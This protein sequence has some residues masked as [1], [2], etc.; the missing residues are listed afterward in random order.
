MRR[1]PTVPPNEI[2]S[3]PL[4]RTH[5]CGELRADHIGQEVTLCGWVDTYRDHGGGVFIDLRDRYG[6]SQ[7]VAGPESGQELIDQAKKLRSEDVV[8]VIGKVAH[9]P[10][11]QDNPKLDTGEI[12]LRLSALTLLNKC[13]PPPFTPS[14]SELPGEDLRLQHRYIDLRRPKMQEIL[15]SRGRI[16]KLMRDYFEENQFVDI[17]TPIL[18]RS[19]PEGARDY[20]V[21][22]RIHHSHF[23][24]LPQSP[25]LYKQIM[26]IAGYD[27]YVQSRALLSR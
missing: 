23:Y 18:G 12:E 26:M 9:R 6:L 17:E 21:P 15:L 1:S 14:Q 11:G 24:A 3:N 27:R 7:I 13:T 22:S 4:L 8:Q 5:T 19:T 20:L 25:Q 10:A 2:W 16:I